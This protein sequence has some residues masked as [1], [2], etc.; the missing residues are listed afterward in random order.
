MKKRKEVELYINR[1]RAKARLAGMVQSRIKRPWKS[2]K[3]DRL[4]KIKTLD[5]SFSS[6]PFPA[7][8]VMGAENLSFSY[9]GEDLIRDF[10]IT[11]SKND[12]IAVIGKNG[13]GRPRSCDSLPGSFSP[14]SG[15]FITTA[16]PEQGISPRPIPRG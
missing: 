2:R 7:R 3:L 11:V 8:V 10:S 4:E 13:R 12:R 16:R 1:F 6:R 5:F 14:R 15:A 9:G